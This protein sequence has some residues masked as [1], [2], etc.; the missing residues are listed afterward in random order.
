MFCEGGAVFRSRGWDAWV[1]APPGVPRSEGRERGF[2][3]STA[4]PP[5]R[6]ASS[7]M[8]RPRS[9][10][11]PRPRVGGAP[12]RSRRCARAFECP[13]PP[14]CGD[15]SA[16]VPARRS[17]CARCPKRRRL[18][19][20]PCST[21][22]RHTGN[23]TKTPGHCMVF[24]RHPGYRGFNPLRFGHI[25]PTNPHQSTPP[26][27]RPHQNNRPPRERR[28]ETHEQ[29]SERKVLSRSELPLTSCSASLRGSVACAAVVGAVSVLKGRHVKVCEGKKAARKASAMWISVDQRRSPG[30]GRR[31]SRMPSAGGA[32]EPPA[33]GAIR[34]ITGWLP[35]S[36]PCTD[37]R[38][39]T[40][41]SVRWAALLVWSRS[42]ARTGRPLRAKTTA[43]L[44]RPHL[45][46]T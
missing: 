45:P 16:L 2:W 36:R 12:P 40:R 4:R 29:A 3:P 35:A 32:A 28:I 8:M 21:T 38:V 23:T 5:S 17:E 9:S 31:C 22:P 14:R 33:R 6:S 27:H 43:T 19:R 44:M 39:R 10:D 34:V 24:W 7:L 25:R 11:R 42:I 37:R 15:S 41:R 13:G 46:T 30:L 20:A 18:A 26:A 1:V